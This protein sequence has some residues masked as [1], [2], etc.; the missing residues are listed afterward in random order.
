[1]GSEVISDASPV[2]RYAPIALFAYNR[3]VHLRRTIEALRQNA[4]SSVSLL[5]VFSD[6]PKTERERDAVNAVRQYVRDIDGF[7]A[8]HIVEQNENYGLARSII[9]GVTHVC[10]E[11]GRVIVLED[12]MVISRYF[13]RFM[14]D[15]LE[16]YESDE[17]VISIHGYVYPIERSLP[18]SWFLKA[19]HC[20]GWATW[21]RGW[22]CFEPDGQR[23]LDELKRRGLS[24][25][26]D[27]DGSYPYT[28]MLQDQI[29]G[30]N[31][32]WAIRWYAS[33]F[34][35]DKLTL[36]P[37]RNLVYNTGMDGTGT[38]CS[39]TNR[40]SS[41]IADRP[42]DLGAI[43]VAE[44]AG[45]RR[46]ISGFFKKTQRPAPIRFAARVVRYLVHV[47]RRR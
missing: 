7:A 30:R 26:F 29:N 37:G 25:Q 18:E 13:L 1:V 42:I 22:E 34:L 9:T 43:G 39:V 11:Y 33:A 41:G 16:R 3:V 46:A 10:N 35:Q 12:D 23:L 4:E 45:A 28:Q 27:F 2:N 14:N 36:Y 38:H 47:L 15:A 31:N 21:R 17:R 32:S 20:W 40:F 8:V 6:A 44:D 5:C 19:A 24:K